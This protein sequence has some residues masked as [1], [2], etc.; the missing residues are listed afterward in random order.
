MTINDIPID[1][2]LN[3]LPEKQAEFMI[4]KYKMALGRDRGDSVEALAKR[5][6]MTKSGA[7]KILAK[8]KL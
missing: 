5:H 3:N 2:V 7:Y 1:F 8:I 4:I 6:F